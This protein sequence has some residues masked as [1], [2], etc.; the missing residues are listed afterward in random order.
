MPAWMRAD[1]AR[2]ACAPG[3]QE[4]ERL[5]A[6]HLADRDTVGAQA[7]RRADEIGERG[8]AVLGAQRHEVG[9]RALQL[10]RILDQH[11]AV[12]GLGDL[13]EQRVGERGLAGRSAAGDEDVLALPDRR[14]Q[15]LP[16]AR[17]T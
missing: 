2:M 11:H 12:G 10:A 5:G 9:R 13:G 8:D 6:A 7:Q 15:Q 17:R 16:P 14:A 4:I 1:A 3:F